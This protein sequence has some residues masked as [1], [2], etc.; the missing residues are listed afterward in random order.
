MD[1]TKEIIIKKGIEIAGQE[2]IQAIT[3]RRIASETGVNVAAVNY[4]FHS[5]ENLLREIIMSFIE[6]MKSILAQLFFKKT[7]DEKYFED[8]LMEITARQLQNP[9][10]IKSIYISLISG[11]AP[12]KHVEEIIGSV[13]DNMIGRAVETFGIKD[14][15]QV[16][17]IFVQIFA[18]VLYPI[19]LGEFTESVFKLDYKNEKVRRKYIRTIIQKNIPGGIQWKN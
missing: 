2:G 17:I 7:L 18:D 1:K 5:K 11:A 9:G 13:I 12:I 15:E 19:L 14:H 10:I 6:D 4:H 3:I 16:R 8:I